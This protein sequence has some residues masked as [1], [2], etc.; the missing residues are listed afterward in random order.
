MQETNPSGMRGNASQ[1]NETN[2][3]FKTKTT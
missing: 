3:F 2:L 1:D